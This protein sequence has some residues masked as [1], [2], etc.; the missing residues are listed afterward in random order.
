MKRE[1]KVGRDTTETYSQAGIFRYKLSTNTVLER[2][3]GE[4]CNMGQPR[5]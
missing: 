4:V 5:A 3:G 1:T 2:F